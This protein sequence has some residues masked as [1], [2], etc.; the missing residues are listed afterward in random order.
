MNATQ[1][2]QTVTLDRRFSA[3]QEQMEALKQQEKELREQR[4]IEIGNIFVKHGMA[5]LD[6]AIYYGLAER[7]RAEPTDS[8]WLKELEAAGAKIKPKT[9]GRKPSKGKA[10]T[11]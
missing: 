7:L 8:A 1:P 9:A 11:P 3:I 6:D 4:A 10:G 5:H 2:K